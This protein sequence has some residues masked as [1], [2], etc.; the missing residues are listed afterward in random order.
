[1]KSTPVEAAEGF[2]ATGPA[3]EGPTLN[4][5]ATAQQWVA[6]DGS[7]HSLR[8]RM[9]LKKCA[10]SAITLFTIVSEEKGCQKQLD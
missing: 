10:F 2:S 5:V 8:K 7:S 6:R 4:H 9:R 3:T 1:M